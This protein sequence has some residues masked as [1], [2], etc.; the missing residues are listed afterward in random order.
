MSP[1]RRSPP[2]LAIE[3]ANNACFIVRDSTRQAVGYFYFD[4]TASP[5]LPM[6]INWQFQANVKKIPAHDL[7]DVKLLFGTFSQRGAGA[8]AIWSRPLMHSSRLEERR[9]SPR[10]QLYRMAKIKLGDGT[11]HDC[12]VIDISD[13]GVRLNVGG[14]KV[15]DKFVLLLFGDGVVRENVYKKVWHY[16][17]ELG[18]KLVRIVRSGFALQA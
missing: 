14:L 3:E 18:A 5:S 16:G 7:G 17:H 2:P 12:L 13:E 6:G 4:S 8:A 1:A 9:R 10:R 15:P 11:P